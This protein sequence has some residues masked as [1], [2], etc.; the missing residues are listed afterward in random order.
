MVRPARYMISFFGI[1]DLLAILP[2]YLSLIIPGSHYFLSIRV[3]RLLRIF[4][5][6]KLTEYVSEGHVITEALK[7]VDVR[8]VCFCSQC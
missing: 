4:R 5:V 3:L 6:F 8:S 7:E 2:T 1:V